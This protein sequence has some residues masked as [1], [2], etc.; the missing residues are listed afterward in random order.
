LATG[1]LQRADSTCPQDTENCAKS[2][3][4]NS[5]D[6]LLFV[7][8]DG[9][10]RNIVNS[11]PEKQLCLGI[12]AGV[13]IH[14][15]V[16]AINVRG[17]SEMLENL[18]ARK[19]ISVDE[20]EVRDIDEVAFREGIVRARYYG[21]LLTPQ[22]HH[23]LQRVKCGG[24]E[25]ESLVL[26]DI[27]DFLIDQMDEETIYVVGPGTTTRAVMQALDLDNTLLGVDLIQH[28]KLLKNDASER[29]ILD[30]T[31][32]KST[33]I[34]ITLIGGQGHILG[35]GNPQISAKVIN[36]VGHENLMVLSPKSKLQELNGRP[37]LVDTIDATLNQTL[38]GLIEVITG[39]ED[40][41]V[42]QVS[43]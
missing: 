5:V 22:D 15:G 3:V 4:A 19:I 30:L 42:Y 39:Y 8:G 16:F 2:I 27:A 35:R 17:A 23:N 14:S 12:P 25:V 6:I 11:V 29:D 32:G 24:R 10:A 43:H 31:L 26:Q 36:Q 21:Q 7:G 34:L 18:I 13:K 38:T 40:R 37:L 28:K 41:V 1:Y 20:R 9:T 33:K